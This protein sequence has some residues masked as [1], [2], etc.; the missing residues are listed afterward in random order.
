MEIGPKMRT[1]IIA[2]LLFLSFPALA[3][4]PNEEAIESYGRHIIRGKMVDGDKDHPGEAPKSISKGTGYMGILLDTP[5]DVRPIL[6]QLD[7]EALKFQPALQHGFID[8]IQVEFTKSQA[9]FYQIYYGSRVQITCNIDFSGR[10]YT[11]IYCEAMAVSPLELH[12]DK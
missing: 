6:K 9:E 8:H 7:P 4:E 1:P 12:K 11:P 3:K 5:L 10:F 2:L